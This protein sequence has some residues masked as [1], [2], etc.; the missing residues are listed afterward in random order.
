MPLFKEL[1]PL[2]EGMTIEQIRE[3]LT[4]SGVLNGSFVAVKITEAI[5]SGDADKLLR[6][7]KNIDSICDY[8]AEQVI[9][10]YNNVVEEVN[11]RKGVIKDNA[12]I[13]FKVLVNVLKHFK[14]K[15]PFGLK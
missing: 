10:V 12:V 13:A 3:Q 7:G 14:V 1:E 8:P 2:Q 9:T 15:L 11:T 5:L 4:N 6:K